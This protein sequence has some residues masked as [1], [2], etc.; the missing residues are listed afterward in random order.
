M[1]K[2]LITVS[3]LT[4]LALQAQAKEE[5]YVT[6]IKTT[7][8][9]SISHNLSVNSSVTNGNYTKVDL[10]VSVMVDNMRSQCGHESVSQ[11]HTTEKTKTETII[12]LHEVFKVQPPE[13]VELA[14]G[15]TVTIPTACTLMVRTKR[16]NFPVTIYLQKSEKEKNVI[17]KTQND[18]LRYSLSQ[19]EEGNV[20]LY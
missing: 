17:V 5:I 1:K 7:R 4:G 8:Q 6:K 19:D 9:A 11:F 2:L 18:T 10:S 12:N 3:L 15:S 14:D 16:V 20:S 13:V